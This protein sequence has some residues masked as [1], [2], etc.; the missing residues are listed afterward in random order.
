MTRWHD[1]SYPRDVE[2]SSD[3]QVSNGEI[4]S[5]ILSSHSS[6]WCFATGFFQQGRTRDHFQVS[7]RWEAKHETLKAIAKF[8]AIIIRDLV[9]TDDSALNSASSSNM[10]MSI[11][12]FFNTC[13]NFSLTISIKETEVLYQPARGKQYAEPSIKMHDAA[14][15][16]VDKFWVAPC[17]ERQPTRTRSTTEYSS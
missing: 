13:D 8:K 14:L 15:G 17:Q 5:C 9:V 12:Q 1:G 2:A 16:V 7:Y 11:D 6:A 3:F 4:R 10:Q